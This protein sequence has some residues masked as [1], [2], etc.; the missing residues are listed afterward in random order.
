[1]DSSDLNIYIL[2]VEQNGRQFADDILKSISLTD[3]TLI[4]ISL[5]FIP[6]VFDNKAALAQ[7]MA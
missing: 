3:D 4:K 2:R 1:M 6:R 5:K 7:V